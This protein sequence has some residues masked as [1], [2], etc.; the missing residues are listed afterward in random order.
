MISDRKK[1]LI[2]WAY[3][4][5]GHGY[6]LPDFRLQKFLFFYEC[7]SKVE[8]DDFDFNKL[9]GYKRGP[10]FGDVFGAMKHNRSE[11]YNSI[12]TFQY[13]VNAERAVQSMFLVQAL[14]VELSDF[15]HK[16]NMWKVKENEIM[17]GDLH[18]PLVGKD[19][20]E[21][22]AKVFDELKSVYSTSYINSV[23][24]KEVNGKTFLFP[25][26]HEFKSEYNNALYEVS[27]DSDFLSPV[28][29]DVHEGELYFE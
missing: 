28:Y 5:S 25:K 7:L 15:T 12:K 13:H 2:N 14:G 26:E 22:D 16:L 19:F 20:S 17:R 21:H 4:E 1:A 23:T 24:I 9:K 27:V 29:V 3:S 10:V 8:G 11:F 18:V 6:D